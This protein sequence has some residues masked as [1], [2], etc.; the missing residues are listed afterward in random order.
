MQSLSTISDFIRWGAS[1]FHEAGLFF[2]HG[3]DN[4]LDEAAALVLHALHMPP[5]LHASWFQS[6]LTGEERERVIALMQRR[7]DERLPLPYLTGEAW[8]A[9]LRFLV[10]TQVLIPRSPIAELIEQGFAPWLAADRIGRVL[11]LCTGSGCIGIASAIYLPESEVDLVD[12]SAAAIAVCEKNIQLYDLSDR[13]KAIESDLFASLPPAR[14]DVIVSNPPYVG[15]SEMS[16]LPPEY[17]HE[18]ELALHAEEEGLAIVKRILR[19]SPRYLAPDGVLIVEVGNSAPLLQ[20]TYPEIPFTWLDFAKGGDGVF[21]LRAD[22]LAQY[23]DV[24]Q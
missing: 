5:D 22:D 3:T 23:A 8:F 17:H 21:L 15:A 16:D 2:G 20:E 7:I 18:P 24:Q 11:D 4:A 19:D 12:I 1:R 9:G 10:D 14:Y 6:R 13:V